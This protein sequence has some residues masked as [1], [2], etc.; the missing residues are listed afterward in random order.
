M[1][2]TAHRKEI[3][4]IKTQK[5]S[6]VYNNL[7][8]KSM[9]GSIPKGAVVVGNNTDVFTLTDGSFLFVDDW[10]GTDEKFIGIDINGNSKPNII[11]KDYFLFVIKK[12][13]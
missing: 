4:K 13:V 7:K 3:I 8:Y 12:Q 10:I 11:G 6:V 2:N 1:I 5:A 9:D